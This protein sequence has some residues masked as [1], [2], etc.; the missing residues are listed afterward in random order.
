MSGDEHIHSTACL[1]EGCSLLTMPLSLERQPTRWERWRTWS[2]TPPVSTRLVIVGVLAVLLCLP[3]LLAGS[4]Q[5]DTFTAFAPSAEV[6]EHLTPAPGAPALPQD[7]NDL[8]GR[9][10]D[11]LASKPVPDITGMDLPRALQALLAVGLKPDTFDGTGQGRTPL[12]LTRWRVVGQ[13]PSAGT[14]RA[15]GTEVRVCVVKADE[16]ITGCS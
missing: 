4:R 12:V 2:T 11:L 5:A 9:V 10:V 6:P 7:L 14:S 8:Q 13:S 3:A 15:P 1:E 16:P